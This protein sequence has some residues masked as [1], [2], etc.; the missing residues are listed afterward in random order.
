MSSK[1][2]EDVF[3]TYLR[4][5]LKT[6]WR[7]LG[8]RLEKVLKTFLQDVLKTSSKCLQDIWTRPI[9]WS[10][11]RRLEDVFWRRKINKNIFIFMKTSWRRLLKTKTKDVFIKANACWVPNWYYLL[12]SE[13]KQWREPCDMKNPYTLFMEL[14]YK[15]SLTAESTRDIIMLFSMYRFGRCRFQLY[16]KLY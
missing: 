8:R 5:V 7:C 6:F 16:I 9:C 1:R 12:K 3:K 15:S 11:P 4:D 10:W 13:E 14:Y 2:L